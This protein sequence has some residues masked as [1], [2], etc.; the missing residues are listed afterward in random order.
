MIRGHTK[1]CDFIHAVLKHCSFM[2]ILLLAKWHWGRFFSEYFGFA[3]SK[4]F[5]IFSLLT[6]LSLTDVIEVL[7][8]T[9][10]LNREYISH[11]LSLCR[12]IGE[13]FYLMISCQEY[14]NIFCHNAEYVTRYQTNWLRFHHYDLY[15]GRIRVESR[16]EDRISWLIFFVFTL[17]KHPVLFIS[18]INELDAQNFCFTISLFHASTCF[19]HMCSSSGGKNFITQ[20]LLSSHL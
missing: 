8:L 5:R 2:W 10:S 18:V 15:W 19:E 6:Q 9:A 13:R 11:F 1:W 16:S 3:Q 14:W 20:P 12:H 17:R 7:R 4:S